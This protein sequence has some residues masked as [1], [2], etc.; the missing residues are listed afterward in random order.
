MHTFFRGKWLIKIV[1]ERYINGSR[2]RL[3]ICT[4]LTASYKFNSRNFICNFM[5][6]I[7]NFHYLIF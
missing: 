1:F 3:K 5:Q 6:C 4:S 7:F 2:Y